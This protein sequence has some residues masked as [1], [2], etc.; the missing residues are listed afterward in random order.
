MSKDA[1]V[2]FDENSVLRTTPLGWVKFR[3]EERFEK[4]SGITAPFVGNL[5]CTTHP[6]W[7]GYAGVL[8]EDSETQRR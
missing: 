3:D 4:A 5:Y 2:R 7:L 1:A 6:G 8:H